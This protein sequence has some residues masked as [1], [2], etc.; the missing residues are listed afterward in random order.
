MAVDGLPVVQVT[1]SLKKA[2]T[3]LREK[4]AQLAPAPELDRYAT[5]AFEE[6]AQ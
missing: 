2:I 3:Q 6:A 1:E 5:A 4:A